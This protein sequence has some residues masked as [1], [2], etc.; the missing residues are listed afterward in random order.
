M[1]SKIIA[2]GA[3]MLPFVDI[4]HTYIHLSHKV[5]IGM[6]FTTNDLQSGILF[7]IS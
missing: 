1:I 2:V 6:N 4:L 5:E 7:S 3:I